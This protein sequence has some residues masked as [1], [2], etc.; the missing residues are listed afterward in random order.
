M[1]WEALPAAFSFYLTTF[2]VLTKEPVILHTPPHLPL[3]VFRCSSPTSL[4]SGGGL[5]QQAPHAPRGTWPTT[6]PLCLSS[7]QI[8]MIH[9]IGNMD[10]PG[11]M[12]YEL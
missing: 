3:T 11:V 12:A 6:I 4:G 8:Y 5:T 2:S 7:C 10:P 9:L 1:V